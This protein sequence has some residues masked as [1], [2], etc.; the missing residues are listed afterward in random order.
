MIIEGHGNLLDAEVDALV[1]TVNTVGVMGR[2]IA[3]QFKR[4]YPANFRAY[5]AACD[6]GAVRLGQMYVFDTGL[7]GPRRFIINFPTKDHWRNRSRLDD[8]ATGLDSLVAVVAEHRVSSIAIPALGCGNGG[9]DWHDVRPMIEAAA[10]RMPGARVVVYPPEGAP[11]P[12]AMPSV[13]KPPTL[14]W[15]IALL[16]VA[17]DKYLHR[18][19]L[20][21][22]REGISELE[23]Q[24]VAYFLQEVGAPLGFS[25][26]RGTYGP[27]SENLTRLLHRIEGHYM[28][29]LGD[30]SAPVSRLRPINL[31]PGTIEKASTVLAGEPAHAVH[32]DTMLD[33]VDGFETPYSIELLATVHFAAAQKPVT[34]DPADLSARV[35]SWSLRK[36]RLFT[37]AHV[38]LAVRTLEDHQL[39]PATAAG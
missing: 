27:Y 19:H 1:N 11:D 34:Q 9:L 3:L 22:V 6:R 10:A 2:G 35:V 16:L 29:G 37:D 7:S 13:T 14:T 38:R 4:A 24:K 15:R 28:V 36:A 33:L 17:F 8:I 32:L 23:I 31:T 26:A 21:E 5:R 30:R 25:F 39:L 18:A 12:A 20:Q